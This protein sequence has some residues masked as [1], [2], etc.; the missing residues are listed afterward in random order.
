MTDDSRIE[1]KLDTVIALLRIGF[2]DAL[3][4]EREIV[5]GDP[6]S[7]A[8]L[9]NAQ[10]WVTAGELKSRVSQQTHQSEPTVKRRVAELVSSG[11]LGRLGRGGRVTYRSTGL[12]DS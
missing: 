12:L 9:A 5:K 2:R 7:E 10:E 3:D 4:R 11:A 8:I 6:V 1:Q